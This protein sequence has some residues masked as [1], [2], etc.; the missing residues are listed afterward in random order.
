MKHVVYFTICFLAA[1]GEG[2]QEEAD[3][4]GIL[5]NTDCTGQDTTCV[6]GFK[7]DIQA[8]EDVN[9]DN[10]IPEVT[11][12]PLESWSYAL[13]L[14]CENDELERN[15]STVFCRKSYADK[16]FDRCISDEGYPF[17]CPF[18]ATSWYLLLSANVNPAS[19]LPRSLDISGN[20]FICS[21]LTCA[22]SNS[23]GKW[24]PVLLGLGL[25]LCMLLCCIGY[26]KWRN[27]KIA[28]QHETAP[29]LAPKIYT[30]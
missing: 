11:E 5:F 28:K 9:I 16:N 18:P 12:V 6:A 7:L 20:I 15:A 14:V 29:I 27:Y 10:F 3:A 24:V 17:T 30:A 19:Q 23:T 8:T 26:T 2:H 22:S 4:V 25:A 21:S 13:R 1:V